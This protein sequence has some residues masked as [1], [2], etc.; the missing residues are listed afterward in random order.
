MKVNERRRE[1]KKLTMGGEELASMT[2]ALQ[3]PTETQTKTH[4]FGFP[5]SPTISKV[6]PAMTV[7][8]PM[9][10]EGAK[11]SIKIQIQQERGKKRLKL[12]EKS[13]YLFSDFLTDS[14]MSLV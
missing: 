14:A 8:L 12:K 5:F 1:E 4:S 6:K 10:C 9:S 3:S 11:S 13:I 2:K 7:V